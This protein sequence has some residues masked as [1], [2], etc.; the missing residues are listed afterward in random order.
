MSIDELIE[1]WT[2][3]LSDAAAMYEDVEPAQSEGSKSPQKVV[4]PLLSP[5][6]HRSAHP[7]RETL[8]KRKS[9]AGL[10]DN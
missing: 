5:N 9:R 6:R 8:A 4:L 10:F 1:V 7:T 2:D 3:F